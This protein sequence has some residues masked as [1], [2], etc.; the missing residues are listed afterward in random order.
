MEISMKKLYIAIALTPLITGQS[1]CM[2][3]A[4]QEEIIYLDDNG[5]I[6]I[7]S[8]DL[9]DVRNNKSSSKDNAKKESNKKQTSPTAIYKIN[10][11]FFLGSTIF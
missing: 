11:L 10:S 3:G 6:P 7:T 9:Y 2:Q 5:E 4:M 8:K 1:C